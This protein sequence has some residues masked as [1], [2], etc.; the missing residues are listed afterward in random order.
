LKEA[1]KHN[2]TGNNHQHKPFFNTSG[3]EQFFGG[4]E[5]AK[6]N[7]EAFFKT[8]GAQPRLEVGKKDDAFEK[9]AD[10]TADKVVQKLSQPDASAKPA[11]QAKAGAREDDK[12]QQKE[13][14]EDQDKSEQK[15]QRKAIFESDEP[16]EQKPQVQ[17]KELIMRKGNG[18]P[19]AAPAS[20]E[21][22]LKS[23]KGGGA[24]MDSGTRRNMESAFGADFSGVR[25]HN[26][27][28]AKK[29]SNELGAQAFTHGNDIY[30]NEGKYDPNSSSGAHLLAHELTHTV[31]QGA[32]V[33][34][35]DKEDGSAAPDVQ[36]M[37]QMKADAPA[38]PSVAASEVVDISGGQFNPSEALK[39]EIEA[40]KWKGLDVK[41]SAS[42]IGGSMVTTK[43][44]GKKNQFDSLNNNYFKIPVNIPYLA[45]ANPT[46]HVKISN[47]VATGE[48]GTAKSR[49]DLGNWIA[50]NA[51]T[52]G[53][54]GVKVP[55]LS[56]RLTNKF[57]NGILNLG[58]N[59][60]SVKVAQFVTATLSAGFQDLQKPVVSLAATVK[61]KGIAEGTLNINNEKGPLQGSVDIG[62]NFASFSGNVTATYK[63]DGNIDIRGSVGYSG[64]KL[65]G[66]LTLIATDKA[67]ADNFA[68]QQLGAAGK[69]EEASLPAEVPAAQGK[70]ERA[71][72][73]MGSLTFNLTEWFAG[74]VSVIVDGTGA[75]TVVGKI[76]PPKEIEL[77][78]QKDFD[79]ELFKLE[80]RAAY[81]IPVVGNVFVFANIALKA[82]AK[83]GP[84]KIYNIEVEGTY[85]TN[86]DIAKS[87]TIAG[88]LN[89]SAYAGLRLR[90]EG[91]VGLTV[92][93]HDIKLGVG[94]NADAGVKGY[95]DAR[96]VIGYRDPG[97][98][99]FKGHMEIAAQ[100]F[101]GLSGDLFVEL[102]SPWWSPAPDKKWTW[103]IGSLE[104]PLPGQFGIGAD[105][106][107]VLGSGKVPEISFGK[108]DF[109]GSKFMT[110]LVDKQVP[111]GGGKGT[112]QKPGKFVDGG[113]AG[114]T[115]KPAD[116]KGGDKGG[117]KKAAPGKGG[118]KG[119]DKKG[120][121][122]DK[123]DEL[124][125]MDA[126]MKK[127]KALEGGKPLGKAELTAAVEK[128]K[129][130]HKVAITVKEQGSDIFIVTLN[131]KGKGSKQPAK[132][133]RKKDDGKQPQNA[134][135]K[136]QEQLTKGI[137][138]LQDQDKKVAGDGKLRKDEAEKVAQHVKGTHSDVFKSITV[139]DGG[140]NWKYHY[141]QKNPN[142]G[143]VTG[144]KEEKAKLPDGVT[145]GMYVRHKGEEKDPKS[146]DEY[147]APSKNIYK[148]LELDEKLNAVYMVA[149]DGKVKKP[150]IKKFE[151][152]FI[153]LK[154]V[155]VVVPDNIP[156][157][158]N[159]PVQFDMMGYINGRT[160]SGKIR[161][162]D[163]EKPNIEQEYRKQL[164]Q[165]EG[166]ISAM[167][168]YNW[169]KNKKRYEG[170]LVVDNEK[171][172][173]G[174][175]DTGSDRSGYKQ[176]SKE[177]FR[178]K[179]EKELKRELKSNYFVKLKQELDKLGIKHD[180]MKPAELNAKADEIAAKKALDEAEDYVSGKSRN[181]SG[182]AVTHAADG[183]AGG[184]H[185]GFVGMGHAGVN[186]SIGSTWKDKTGELKDKVMDHM[187]KEDFLKVPFTKRKAARMNVTLVP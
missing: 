113:A 18:D 175:L 150:S 42:K 164:K 66:N 90:A 124:K 49:A 148:I 51:E 183:V 21:S 141:I 82:L 40:A 158:P 144:S 97:E 137:K 159:T 20:V 65:S 173:G 35:K 187:R 5:Q 106:E 96:P 75:V 145:I 2:A 112:Q 167:S 151:E 48:V 131:A 182:T 22:S 89:I 46:L 73:G 69:A 140:E 174:R 47:N 34:K 177:T 161:F 186:S 23:S 50:K 123:N 55:S 100:P 39:G 142:A 129:K 10:R 127:V 57:E 169:L 86:P 44:T 72:A 94:V 114:A 152:D 76:A 117:D 122:A 28:N 38:S 130:E 7:P 78:P 139:K 67:T 102:D 178:K 25:I 63:P 27:S 99:F 41:I 116:T 160:K 92:L 84:A 58:I 107:Y 157:L 87:I 133:K 45:A 61:A 12:L 128:I 181:F 146:E 120:K 125:Q 43:I 17:K 13:K 54:F 115:P 154:I 52:L 180:T 11:V 59:G 60:V 64:N 16:Q 165:Q 185:L 80:A 98:F 135:P 53:W 3:P 36:P 108:A 32:S 155:K 101:L 105:M 26:D 29:M 62:I 162:K 126:A 83:V 184:D 85:S 119:K 33:Q 163:A 15:V 176:D 6:S 118:G 88:S 104:Y 134:D 136:K 147:F 19:A 95:V 153:N 179:R 168:I 171:V 37:L 70:G 93:G 172:E 121:D 24:P 103:P 8:T 143:E 77:F 149:Q 81:G 30:F 1:P 109:D 79:K 68:K 166:T 56:G 138:A 9:Q 14:E 31:Q 74:T 156:H 71:M 132:V 91:G 111:S 4:V 110:D 170:S